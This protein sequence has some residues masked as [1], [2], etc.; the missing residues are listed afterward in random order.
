MSPR[1]PQRYPRLTPVLD[2]ITG[3]I[4]LH[5]EADT[6]GVIFCAIPIRDWDPGSDTTDLGMAG[7]PPDSRALDDPPAQ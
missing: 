5:P 6:A 1:E 3:V 4:D 2:I 7:R